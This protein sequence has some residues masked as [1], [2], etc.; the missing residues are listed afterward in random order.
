MAI[1]APPGSDLTAVLDANVR[2]V[3][4]RSSENILQEGEH[5]WEVSGRGTVRF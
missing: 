1:H 3:A 4:F 5:S 2:E